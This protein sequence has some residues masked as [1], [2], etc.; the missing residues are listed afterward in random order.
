MGSDAIVV[1]PTNNV[2]TVLVILAFLVELAA[3]LM[4]YLR[5]GTVFGQGG[6]L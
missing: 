1:R 5:A 3:F 2:Y 6:L 4:M